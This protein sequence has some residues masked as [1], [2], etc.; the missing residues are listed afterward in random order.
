LICGAAFYSISLPRNISGVTAEGG[1]LD[2]AGRDFSKTLYNLDGEWE[3]CYG[4]LL[5]PEDFVGA[6]PAIPNAQF[7]QVPMSWDEAG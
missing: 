2:L 1:V 5:T 4:Q 3:F 7:I 6:Q